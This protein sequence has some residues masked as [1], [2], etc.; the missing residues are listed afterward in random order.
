M[1]N[2]QRL[3]QREAGVWRG[4]LE[5]SRQLVASMDRQL[6]GAEYYTQLPYIR[7]AGAS[8]QV[9]P[10]HGSARIGSADLV[11]PG[12]EEHRH[13]AGKQFGW[14]GTRSKFADVNRVTVEHR[15]VMLGGM[16]RR[17][18]QQGGADSEAPGF[19]P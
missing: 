18:G 1:D 15:S 8:C 14:R 17:S 9:R 11:E 2:T 13:G 7:R 16:V 10:H 5:A 12:F 6:S 4:F 19:A 3:D